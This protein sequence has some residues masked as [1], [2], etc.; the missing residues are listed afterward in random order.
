M[1]KS[2]RFSTLVSETLRRKLGDRVDEY[3]F[4]PPVF[5]AMQGEFLEIDLDS[6]TLTVQF[7]VLDNYLNP[8]GTM[9]GGMIAAA[10]DNTLGPLSVLVA[11]PN[12][13]RRLEMVYSR[14][15]TPD[16]GY[17]VVTS[18]LLE[19]RG[20]WLFFRADVYDNNGRRLARASAAHWIIDDPG[21]T[22]SEPDPGGK[23][24]IPQNSEAISGQS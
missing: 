22:S 14:P 13:T 16:L 19:R 20:R 23:A 8:Y 15:V 24:E 3:A 17:I 2:G 11:P 5:A 10:V 1:Q 18:K 21:R 4:P 7:P 12:V 9:Q 6:G